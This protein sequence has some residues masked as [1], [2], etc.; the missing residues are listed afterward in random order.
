M[1]ILALNLMRAPS[2]EAASTVVS[3]VAAAA[4]AAAVASAAVVLASE[5]VVG[6]VDAANIF[7]SLAETQTYIF[8][9]AHSEGTMEN[10]WDLLEWQLLLAKMSS[11]YLK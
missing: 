4:V 1:Q 11:N 9:K 10:M 2:P 7:L 3:A 5:A 8:V 6:N